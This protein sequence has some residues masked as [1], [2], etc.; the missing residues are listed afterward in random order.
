MGGV[1][2]RNAYI[3]LCKSSHSS[4]SDKLASGSCS[5][6]RGVTNSSSDLRPFACISERTHWRVLGKVRELES[7]L[8]SAL[9]RQADVTTL[10]GFRAGSL[11]F[12]HTALLEIVEV[13]RLVTPALIR[14]NRCTERMN[15]ETLTIAS[16]AGV[17]S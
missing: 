13:L 6:S 12:V 17:S 7:M 3:R 14:F 2:S 16:A 9:E 15:G 4:G 11:R 8:E 10:D 5:E 1:D